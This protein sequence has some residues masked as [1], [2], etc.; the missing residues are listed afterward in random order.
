MDDRHVVQNFETGALECLHCGN[1]YTMA[2]PCNLSV[3]LAAVREY[4]RQHKRCRKEEAR[5]G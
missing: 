2:L 4:I 5:S 3:W 1:S